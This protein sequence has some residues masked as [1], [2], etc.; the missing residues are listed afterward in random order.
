MPPLSLHLPLRLLKPPAYFI[1]RFAV[2]ILNS[3]SDLKYS[4]NATR[5][6]MSLRDIRAKYLP[7]IVAVLTAQFR[8]EGYAP[9]KKGGEECGS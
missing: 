1:Q 9:E 3:F 7:R 6:R 5:L 2:A 8:L 4:Q